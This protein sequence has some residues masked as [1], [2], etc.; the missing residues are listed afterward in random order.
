MKIG[1]IKKYS[2]VENILTSKDPTSLVYTDF[3]ISKINYVGRVV[4]VLKEDLEKF[5][6]ESKIGERVSISCWF[7]KYVKG[8]FHSPHNH[9]PIGYSS[10]CFIEYDKNEHMPTRFILPFNN[11]MTGE[12]NE[13]YPKNLDEGTI[14]FFPSFLNHY[15]LPNK[16]NKLRIILSMNIKKL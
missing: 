8:C 2:S 9:G 13:Y 1:R 10:V 3:G 4:E 14:I 16:S 6:S 5:Y 12:I 11:I 15:V 7:Q